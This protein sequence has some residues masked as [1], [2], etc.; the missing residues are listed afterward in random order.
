[1]CITPPFSLSLKESAGPSFSLSLKRAPARLSPSPLKERRPA[2]L[3]LPQG[4]GRGE[5]VH[6]TCLT[7]STLQQFCPYLRLY[8]ATQKAFRARIILSI[9]HWE[10][11]RWITLNY[12]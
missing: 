11:R 3:P 4:E 8:P 12:L 7:L 6:V 10:S 2:F 9:S 1:M 5:G